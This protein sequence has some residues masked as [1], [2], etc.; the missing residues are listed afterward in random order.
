[1]AEQQEENRRKDVLLE[2]QGFEELW[3]KD[4]NK[5]AAESVRTKQSK[6]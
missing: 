6:R 1:M 4:N 3:K 2:F 5:K